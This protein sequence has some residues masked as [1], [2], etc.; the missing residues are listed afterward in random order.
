[1]SIKIEDNSKQVLNELSKANQRILLYWG[2]VVSNETIDQISQGFGK[3]IV[4]TGRL[5]ASISYA[6][7]E[8]SSGF[9]QLPVKESK[10]DDILNGF[11]DVGSVIIGSNVEYADDVHNGTSTTAGRPFLSRA[12]AMTT[13]KRR[14]GAEKILKG[15]L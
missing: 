11:A 7:P 6:T 13:D 2:N 10:T 12:V 15:E 8:N 5:R 14:N 3:P 9:T 4:D 1:M